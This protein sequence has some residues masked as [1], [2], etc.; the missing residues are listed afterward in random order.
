MKTKLMI[1]T[2]KIKEISVALAHSGKHYERKLPS[3]VAR[4][5]T[6]LPL[7]EELLKEAHLSVRDIEEI[8]VFEGEES[9][10]GVRVGFAI[11]NMLGKLLGVP[12]NG[13]R[14]IA[15]PKYPI[16]QWSE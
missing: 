4:A 1:D 13:K 6:V 9:F 10:T 8:T 16:L 12:V 3:R 15:I 5:Q 7:T 2:S 14:G 11:A